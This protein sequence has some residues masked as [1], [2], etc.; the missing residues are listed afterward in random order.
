MAE[1]LV[2][3]SR[4]GPV[5]ILSLNRAKRHNAL[6]PELLLKLL[7]KLRSDECQEAGAVM[8]RA[9]GRSF[10]TG[11]DMLAFQQNRARIRDY[12]TEVVELL[13]QAI[14]AIYTNTS[15]VVCSVQGQVTGGSLGF[16]LASDW[17]VMHQ[18][19][20]IT[21]WYTTVGFSPDGGWAAM[22]PDIIG[23]QQA[24]DWLAENACHDADTCQKLGLVQKVVSTGC[25]AVAFD[26]ALQ[27][28]IQQTD[29]RA[30]HHILPL[31]EPR[32][33]ELRLELE[34]KAFVEQVQTSQARDGID[35]FLNAQGILKK[36]LIHG[37]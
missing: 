18:K 26:W 32:S 7:E 5:A 15:P 30:R 31:T 4:Q 11:G 22:L 8:L 36:Q 13:N 34:C 25:D 17:V 19:A 27:V 9:E 21:P 23:R 37:S 12:A 28:A 2:K 6:V 29:G 33:L 10:S 24:T 3:L 1:S 20:T 16:L 35:R 14:L